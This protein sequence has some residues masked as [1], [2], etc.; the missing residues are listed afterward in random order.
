[1]TAASLPVSVMRAPYGRMDK[2]SDITKS[3]AATGL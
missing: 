3:P 1:L 2:K